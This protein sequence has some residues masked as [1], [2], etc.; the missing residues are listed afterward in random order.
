MFAQPISKPRFKSIFLNQN[1][2][3]M[4]L[5]L[6][7][8]AKF[9]SDGGSAPRPPCLRRLGLCPQTPSFRQLGASPPDPHWPPAN[10]PK[11]PPPHCGFLATRLMSSNIQYHEC[12]KIYHVM[13]K[14]FVL[15]RWD[16]RVADSF[17]FNAKSSAGDQVWFPRRSNLAQVANGPPLL[18]RYIVRP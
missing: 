5:F 3:K 8:N 15:D 6:Q 10:A 9:S 2:P 18:R 17:V 7:K 14:D 13:K 12:H 11:Q 4:K 1:S 16:G